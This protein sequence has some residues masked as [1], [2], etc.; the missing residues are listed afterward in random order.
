MALNSLLNGSTPDK[1]LKII[2]IGGSN[3]GLIN[4][5]ML[6]HLGHD[7]HILEKNTQSERSDL[8]A[9]ITTHAD[10]DQFSKAHDLVDGPWCID[11][12]GIQFLNKEA[13]VTREVAKDFKMT[14]WGSIYHRLRANFDGLASGFCPNPPPRSEK[15]GTATFDL[16]KVVTR[17]TDTAKGVQVRFDD[18]INPQGHG[19]L[20]AD[21]VI[22]ADGANSNLRGTLFPDLKR[23]YVGYVAFRGTVLEAELS[24]ETK[25]AFS[26]KLT[27]FCWKNNYIL[28]YIIPGAEGSLEPGSRLYNWVWYHPLEVASPDFTEIMTDTSGTLHR[29]T[30]PASSMNLT[31]WSK[32]K[33]IA[34]SEMCAPFADVVQ[35]ASQ[36]FITAVSDLACPRAVAMGGRLLI[37]GE[38]L[39]LVRPHLALS[40]TA[41]AKQALLLE[42]VFRGEM[43][44]EQWERQVL[45][46]GR[47]SRL[48]TNAYGIWLL[49]GAWSAVGWAVKLIG[50]M[51]GGYMPFSTLPP[52][53]V[54]EEV[55]S[56][57]DPSM[58]DIRN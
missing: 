30:L 27:Y 51:I 40:T 57:T 13:A 9:G 23:E 17:L 36:P 7:V 42:K 3:T 6:K 14:S 32:Y 29:N 58:S 18:L 15:D 16:G 11:C 2:I 56:K 8:A 25:N 46:E 26:S 10:F 54:K 33:E 24:E 44:I 49:Y 50:A 43:S 47:I 31:A 20:T 39:N 28:L 34:T 19:T 1:T 55:N 12:P 22:L 5:I 45:Y 38:A 4:G 48:Q 35:K 41:S 53:P 21:L 37:V 52:I